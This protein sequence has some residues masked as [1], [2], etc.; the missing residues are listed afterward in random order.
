M[1]LYLFRERPEQHAS[2]EGGAAVDVERERRLAIFRPTFELLV[3]LVGH[4]SFSCTGPP[5]I[6]AFCVCSF[7]LYLNFYYCSVQLIHSIQFWQSQVSFRVTYP[8]GFETWRKDELADFKSTRY[9][10]FLFGVYSLIS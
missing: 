1:F 9:G 8:P 3:S 7:L 10:K 6:I 4:N 5:A 2:V